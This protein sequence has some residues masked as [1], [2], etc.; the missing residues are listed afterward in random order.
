[1]IRL[2]EY[3]F[4]FLIIIGIFYILKFLGKELMGGTLLPFFGLNFFEL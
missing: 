4:Y 3:D 2:K 1:M